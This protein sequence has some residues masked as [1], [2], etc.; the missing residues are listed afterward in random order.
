MEFTKEGYPILESRQEF[1]KRMSKENIVGQDIHDDDGEVVWEIID[2]VPS[3]QKSENKILKAWQVK[4][5]ISK[6]PL[7]KIF[8]RMYK[9]SKK[10]A[11]LENIKTASPKIKSKSKTVVKKKEIKSVKKTVVKKAAKTKKVSKNQAGLSK[12]WK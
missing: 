4:V 10:D 11:P 5:V 3:E 6:G 2:A 12:K 1:Y 9:R 7:V 8:Q